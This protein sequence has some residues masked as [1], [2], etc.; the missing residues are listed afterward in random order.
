ML[1][2]LRESK[3]IPASFVAKKLGTTRERL[4]RIEDGDVTLPTEFIP[5][6]CDLYGI[7][8]E[9]LVNRRVE[10]WKNKKENC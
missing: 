7:S 1:R 10:E 4:K 2:L 9:E 6:L 5:V 8:C 3:G